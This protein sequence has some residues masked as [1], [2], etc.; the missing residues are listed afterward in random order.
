MKPT[1]GPVSVEMALDRFALRPS[2]YN[3]MHA[4]NTPIN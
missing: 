4:P 3:G 2:Y 1:L